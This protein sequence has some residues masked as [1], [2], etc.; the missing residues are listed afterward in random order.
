MLYDYIGQPA[1]WI[2]SASVDE[3]QEWPTDDINTY[4]GA[5]KI[6]TSY[7]M[8]KYVERLGPEGVLSD[9]I[10]V[11]D[12]QGTPS[13]FHQYP[14]A[15]HPPPETLVLPPPYSHTSRVIAHKAFLLT[16]RAH[17]RIVSPDAAQD[18]FSP[19]RSSGPCSRTSLSPSH[20]TRDL[21][22][23]TPYAK[24]EDRYLYLGSPE[25]AM[26]VPNFNP[27]TVTLA[28]EPAFNIH[29]FAWQPNAIEAIGDAL[30]RY[31][32]DCGM[33]KAGF[34]VVTKGGCR[35]T[36]PRWEER[37]Q[38]WRGLGKTGKVDIDQWHCV[39][40]TAEESKVLKLVDT[41]YMGLAWEQFEDKLQVT[42]KVRNNVKGDSQTRLA[43]VLVGEV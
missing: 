8:G 14:L 2:V 36:L 11:G 6:E 32:G 39:D 7:Y 13:I 38:V 42:S 29:R 20:M 22:N 12:E 30:E 34:E 43:G 17:R 10:A 5:L 37:A 21:Y 40:G 25:D 23:M 3:F 27:Y 4:L 31:R 26:G 33:N 15:C 18:Y 41:G 19:C 1:D 28:E 35:P 9:V 16:G 24:Y